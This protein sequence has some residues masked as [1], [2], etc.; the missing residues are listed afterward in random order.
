[1]LVDEIEKICHQT[2]QLALEEAAALVLDEATLE[3]QPL[4]TTISSS[5]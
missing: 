5:A 2:K 3:P 4:Q 1:M